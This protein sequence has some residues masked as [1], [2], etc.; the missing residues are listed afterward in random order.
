MCCSPS[1]RNVVEQKHVNEWCY[2]AVLNMEVSLSAHWYMRP[3]QTLHS[4]LELKNRWWKGKLVCGF[5][6]LKHS[7]WSIT[8]NCPVLV[9]AASC[10]IPSVL[11]SLAIVVQFLHLLLLEVCGFFPRHLTCW[12]SVCCLLM[13]MVHRRAMVWDCLYLCICKGLGLGLWS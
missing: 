12:V 9:I 5:Y 8:R 1:Y 4:P 7:H 11:P 2:S 3:F 10:K 13:G 6:C